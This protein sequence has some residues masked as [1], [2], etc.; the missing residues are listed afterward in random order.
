MKRRRRNPA[1]LYHHTTAEKAARI[2][3]EQRLR[4]AGEPDVYVTTADYDIG[5][6]PAAVPICVPGK[7]LKLDDEFP[8]GRKDYRISVRRPSG[9]VPVYAGKPFPV[10]RRN[11]EGRFLEPEAVTPPHE[12]KDQAKFRRLVE[13]MS[14]HGWEGRPLLGIEE[15]GG[16]IQLLTGSHRFAAAQEAG[17]DIPISVIAG[18]DARFVRDNDYNGARFMDPESLGQ[19][20]GEVDTEAA[21]LLYQED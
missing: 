4:S 13:S 6:G 10:R 15:E 1:D 12:V 16:W 2:Y 14:A 3:R 11:P 21:D 18:A 7:W 19:L 17:I 5:Y 9:S 20:I 8:D